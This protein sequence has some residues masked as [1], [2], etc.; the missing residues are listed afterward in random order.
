MNI[1]QK[2]LLKVNRILRKGIVEK[3]YREDLDLRLSTGELVN[4][5]FWEIRKIEISEDEKYKH[6]S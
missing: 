2:V 1:G 6:I 5:K 4:R 3:I